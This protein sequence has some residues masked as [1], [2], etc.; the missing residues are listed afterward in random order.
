MKNL[1]YVFLVSTLILTSAAMSENSSKDKTGHKKQVL[2]LM[3]KLHRTEKALAKKFNRLSPE[4]QLEVIDQTSDDNNSDDDNLN[5]YIEGALDLDKCS[6]DSDDDGLDDS[7]ELIDGS[8]PSD[9]DSDNDGFEDGIEFEA[10]G[11]LESVD[12]VSL[13]VDGEVYVLD[14]DTEYLDGDNNVIS[15]EDLEV[16]DC[17]GIEGHVAGVDNIVE[18]VKVDDDCE[19]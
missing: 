3:K 16:G 11:F 1:I 15:N 7:D 9:D 8:N 14:A 5:D 4:A 12:S 10:H 6:A 19:S 18:K 13:S 17:A 2:Q